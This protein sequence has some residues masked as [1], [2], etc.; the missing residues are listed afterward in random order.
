MPTPLVIPFSSPNNQRRGAIL[1]LCL[2]VL[3]LA[4]YYFV[5]D[6]SESLSS[7]RIPI[8]TNAANTIKTFFMSRSFL[9]ARLHLFWSYLQSSNRLWYH[10]TTFEVEHDQAPKIDSN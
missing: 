3:L 5:F 4:A 2:S 9:S 1:V 6:C 7:T 8:A 10:N